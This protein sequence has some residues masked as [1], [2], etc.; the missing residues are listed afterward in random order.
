[1]SAWIVTDRQEIE[2]LRLAA[3]LYAMAGTTLAG[4]AVI[5]ALTT[6][7]DGAAAIA[8]AAALGALAGVPAAVLVARAILGRRA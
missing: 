1:M 5:V 6:G 7:H 3:T 8:G 4:V 2:M